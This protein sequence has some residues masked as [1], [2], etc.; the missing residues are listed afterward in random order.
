MSNENKPM[1]NDSKA[2]EIINK[3]CNPYGGFVKVITDCGGT[4][5]NQIWIKSMQEYANYRI[6]LLSSQDVSDDAIDARAFLES[7]I[8]DYNANVHPSAIIK[9]S[10]IEMTMLVNAMNDYAKKS[11]NTSYD[12][13]DEAIIDRVESMS[14]SEFENK[15]PQTIAVGAAMWMR[16]IY[17]AKLDATQNKVHDLIKIIA[18]RNAE[19]AE[20]EAREEKVKSRM[21]EMIRY[22]MGDKIEDNDDNEIVSPEQLVNKWMPKKGE[23]E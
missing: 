12:V 15:T 16:S 14:V 6:S 5:V 1:S 4:L 9:L 23:I 18:E 3:C 13:S 11:I 22:F 7:R 20:L 17:S 10:H 19:I 8:D 21:I 2:E